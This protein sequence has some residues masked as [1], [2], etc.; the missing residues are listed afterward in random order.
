MEIP[1]TKDDF[2]QIAS[3]H[4]REL[5]NTGFL[6]ECSI[7]F[8]ATFYEE[9]SKYDS[10]LLF[11]ERSETGLIKG[12]I[13]CS[14]EGDRYYRRFFVKN[15]FMLIPYV[16][17]IYPFVKSAYKRFIT[18]KKYPYY[19]NELVQLAV[20]GQWH[21]KGI[22]KK[23]IKLVEMEFRKRGVSE[24]YLQVSSNNNSGINLYESIGFEIETS[25]E[26]RNKRK[27][28]MKKVLL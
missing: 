28:L 24:Y 12:F 26:V 14:T 17:F 13:F 1:K 9:I 8:L 23:L 27:Y 6:S 20:D 11:V 18:K 25:F 21:G 22:G 16:S 2:I 3:I 15:I 4:K 5:N 7:N 19:R 10:T